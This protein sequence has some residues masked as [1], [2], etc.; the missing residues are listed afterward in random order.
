MNSRSFFS[1]GTFAGVNKVSDLFQPWRVLLTPT[2]QMSV[3]CA[4]D[5]NTMAGSA[6]STSALV[7]D[8]D[9]IGVYSED[10]PSVINRHHHQ[11]NPSSGRTAS[12]RRACVQ[13]STASMN[14]MP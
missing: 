11:R 8:S 2:V 6:I 3:P 9:F 10:T 5:V 1:L 13:G 7:R 12:V 4:K 14:R